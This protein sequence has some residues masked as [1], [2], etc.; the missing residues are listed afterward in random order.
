MAEISHPD[1]E[2]RAEV[3]GSSQAIAPKDTR[4]IYEVAFHV[5]PTVEEAK[6]GDVV[7]KIRTQLASMKAEV[8]AEQFPAKMSLA[9]T[10]ERANAGKREKYNEGYF[11]WIKFAVD[12]REGIPALSEMLR[13]DRE[14]L[15]H[16]IVETVR[17]DMSGPRRAVFSS[18]R[19][20]GETIKKPTSAPEAPA[21][22]SEE[23][24]NKSIDALVS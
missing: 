24:L 17:E 23:D 22:V 18:N 16:L 11:G 5:L 8:L 13:A 10:I 3:E 6:V 12:E 19:L 9:Y 2:A 7:E 4:H 21:Q 1:T 15:R 14:I 20:E